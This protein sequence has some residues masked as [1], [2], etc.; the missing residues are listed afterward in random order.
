M[1]WTLSGS[2]GISV[3]IEQAVG[4]LSARDF[5]GEDAIFLGC[6]S[7]GTGFGCALAYQTALHHPQGLP[8]V[9]P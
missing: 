5:L 8:S 6:P 3:L 4:L 1:A 7:L 9:A 2:V